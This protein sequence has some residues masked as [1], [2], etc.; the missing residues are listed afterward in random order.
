MI[1]NNHCYVVYPKS[2]S[3][4]TRNFLKKIGFKKPLGV[5]EHESIENIIKK[6]GRDDYKFFSVYRDPEDHCISSYKHMIKSN[7]K[8]WKDII[9]KYNIKDFDSWL[10]YLENYKYNWNEKIP[11]PFSNYSDF[12][13]NKDV[14]MLKP[15][16]VKSFMETELSSKISHKFPWVNRINMNIILTQEQKER[17]KKI[18]LPNQNYIEKH[19]W[20]N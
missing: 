17:I 15:T 13:N 4:S 10:S 18:Y 8:C 9:N 6:T 11:H 12:F 2:A 16:Q 1:K 5:F 19:K 7:Y 3:T 20:E 14:I